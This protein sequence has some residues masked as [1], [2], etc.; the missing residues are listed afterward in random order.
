MYLSKDY[1]T[2]TVI[3]VP[4]SA[5]VT[6]VFSFDVSNLPDVK[7]NGYELYA[8]RYSGSRMIDNELLLFT[9]YT[10]YK[11]YNKDKA[12]SYMPFYTEDGDIIIGKDICYPEKPLTST[13]QVLSIIDS[14]TLKT[15]DS[16]SLLSYSSNM[17]VSK[18][19]IY[20]TRQYYESGVTM[21]EITNIGYSENSLTLIGTGRVIGYIKDQYSLDEYNGTLRVA[22]TV[23]AKYDDNN[24][25]VNSSKSASLFILDAKTMQRLAMVQC[26][27]PSG[28]IV[29]SARYEG[30]KAYICT[31]YEIVFSDPVYVFDLSNL[32][33]IT[34]RDTGT[35]DGY[36][37]SLINFGKGYLLGIGYGS[38]S[39]VFKIEVYSYDETCNYI[40]RLSAFS[41]KD[42][43]SFPT[44][45]SERISWIKH[46]FGQD[47]DCEKYSDGDRQI[48]VDII[49]S[50]LNIGFT[51]D[52]DDRMKELYAELGGVVSVAK[53]ELNRTVFSE[54]Y[55]GYYIDRERSLVGLAVRVGGI[56]RYLLLRFNGHSFDTVILDEI[57][58]ITYAEARGFYEDS[59]YYIVT[60]NNIMAIDVGNI[61]KII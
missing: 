52:A 30:D 51:I 10:I 61:S 15:K 3:L 19:S 48:I 23:N 34:Y 7:M 53:Y 50:C 26:F 44:T 27:A 22:S 16:L 55:K 6:A 58:A 12:Q 59:Y 41:S 32:D 31:S 49:S 11:T 8:G 45:E 18:N 38:S 29:R 2:L 14:T 9:S 46:Y 33:N 5:M 56:D 21:T 35:I 54:E 25:I 17:Y 4:R 37:S 39:T 20:L 13:Y 40:S 60:A 28:E 43:I 47:F 36:S 1:K 42:L 24:A 57:D